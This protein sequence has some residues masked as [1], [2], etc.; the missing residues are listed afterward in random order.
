MAEKNISTALEKIQQGIKNIEDKSFNVFF[1]VIDSKGTPSGFLEYIYETALVLKNRGYNVTMIHSDDDFV[2]VGDW[3]N[4]D[5]ANL[6][7]KHVKKDDVQLGLSDFLFI[8]EVSHNVM[9][10]TKN[11][12]CKRI[13]IMQ[14]YNYLCEF[15]PVATT[16][17]TVGIHEVITTTKTQEQ[18]LNDLFPD[19]KTYVVSPAILNKFRPSEEPKKLFINIVAKDPSTINRIVKPF[20]WRYPLYTWVSFRDL[21]SMQQD[22]FAN[23]LREAPITIWVDEPSQFGYSALE[24]LRCGSIVVGKTP[25]R[26]TDW[27]IEGDKLTDSILWFEDFDSLSDIVASLVRTWLLDNIPEDALNVISKF[28]GQYTKE[29]QEAEI[30]NVYENQIFATR[31]KEFEEVAAQLK[32]NQAKTEE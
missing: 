27:Q 6:P 10:L 28:D 14:N 1:Y 5:Y 21:R 23:A 18:L 3:F 7:H 8:P 12:P 2:G 32:N 22:A 4:E 24:A 26:L 15:F 16:P 20:Y 25:E 29:Q 17:D 13:M 19:V 31:K 11:V 9:R 30:T